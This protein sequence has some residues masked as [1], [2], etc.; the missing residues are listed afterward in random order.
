MTLEVWG[1][2]LGM[3][4]TP[5]DE[6]NQTLPVCLHLKCK[7]SRQSTI[8]HHFS[9][10]ILK[11]A[12]YMLGPPLY[13]ECNLLYCNAYNDTIMILLFLFNLFYKD[14]ITN[15]LLKIV[16]DILPSKSFSSFLCS[17]DVFAAAF[18]TR[19]FGKN[20]TIKFSNLKNKSR[21]S[22]VKV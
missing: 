20:N 16:S 11:N 8:R 15:S 21:E 10:I 18:F 13:S 6:Y 2:R 9:P 14:I 19:I 22:G 7:F 5:G 4:F 12:E 1:K 17:C 3:W